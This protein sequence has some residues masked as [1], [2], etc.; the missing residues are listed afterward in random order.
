M[1]F[2]AWH[3]GKILAVVTTRLPGEHN[4]ANALAALATAVRVGVPVSAAVG[5]IGR[6]QGG[7]RRFESRRQGRGLTLVAHY[8]PNPAQERATPQAAPDPVHPRP[9]L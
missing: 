3:E 4:A 8:A 1:R 7:G 9:V 6:F 5:A 2:T